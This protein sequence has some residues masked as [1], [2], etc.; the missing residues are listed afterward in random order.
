MPEAF[1]VFQWHGEGITAPPGSEILAESDDFPVQAFR[2]GGQAYGLLFHLEMDAR[3]V[4]KICT[5]CPGDL[6]KAGRSC[7]SVRDEF[8][9]LFPVT[10]SV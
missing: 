1:R 5:H 4:E 2:V 6:E 3:A 9:A 7:A 8:N 10:N